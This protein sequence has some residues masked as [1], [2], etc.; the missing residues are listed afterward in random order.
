M[1]AYRNDG[2]GITVDAAE[3]CSSTARI[4]FERCKLEENKGGGIQWTGQSGVI[5]RC[6]IYGNGVLPVGAKDPNNPT[7]ILNSPIPI[8]DAYGILIKN[9]KGASNGLSISGCEIQGNSDIQVMIEVGANVK[10]THSDFKADDLSSL[11]SFPTI[12]IQVGDGN[13]GDRPGKKPRA[14]VGCVIEDNRIRG[15]YSKGWE[16]APP[17]TVVKVNTNAICTVIGR[18]WTEQYKEDNIHKLL[19]LVDKVPSNPASH[20]RTL[21][22]DDYHKGLVHIKTQIYRSDI[23]GGFSLLPF[24]STQENVTSQKYEYTPDTSRWCSYRFRLI[25]DAMLLVLKNPTT[26]TIGT[27]LFLEFANALKRDVMV[28]FGNKDEIDNKIYNEYN[29]TSVLIPAAKTVTGILW[30]GMGIK[31][32]LF[33]PW[34][35]EGRP[36]MKPYSES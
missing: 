24:A 9:V 2:W 29:I 4:H 34:T 30:F 10:I 6:G 7:Q 1:F 21:S 26:R 3:G 25:K 20:S 13:I 23:E 22:L 14:V 17:H 16:N 5:E 18:W 27:P 15:T 19:E 33:S 35:C 8:P 11:F 36:L 31:W 28:E 12:D 32:T